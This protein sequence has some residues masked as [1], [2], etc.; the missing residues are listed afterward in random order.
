MD[1]VLCENQCD[2]QNNHC[3]HL[4]DNHWSI[5]CSND[6]A[7]WIFQEGEPPGP[8]QAAFNGLVPGRA[9]NIRFNT[10]T[11]IT[12]VIIIKSIKILIT[13]LFTSVET[14]S[15]GQISEPTTA[16]YRT[17]PLRPYNVTFDPLSIGIL[18][19]QYCYQQ[20]SQIAS[21]LS[22][23]I[24]RCR[25][26]LCT[27]ASLHSSWIIIWYQHHCFHH[28]VPITS[29]YDGE[30][31]LMSQSSTDTRFLEIVMMIVI[32]IILYDFQ[33]SLSRDNDDNKNVTGGNRNPPKD[34]ADNRERSR[35]DRKLQWEPQARQFEDNPS[36]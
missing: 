14:V 24:I 12:I 5:S 3:D 23:W 34:A 18:D 21:L 15:E 16:Q 35:L 19:H 13:F 20:V 28:K 31:P 4:D 22:S 11:I 30:V 8:A 1:G 25:L 36:K 32:V 27:M 26:L 17:V 9:Y 2:E 10:K 29:L 33:W 7:R 6:N